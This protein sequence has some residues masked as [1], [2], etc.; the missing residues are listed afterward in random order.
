MAKN[1]IV[2]HAGHV[3]VNLHRGIYGVCMAN[4]RL[5]AGDSSLYGDASYDGREASDVWP[6]R[7][8]R[9]MALR[10]NAL[11]QWA[12][13]S[14]Y[15]CQAGLAAWLNTGY[16]DDGV[17]LSMKERQCLPSPQMVLSALQRL[18]RRDRI[19]VADGLYAP[20]REWRRPVTSAGQR[21]AMFFADL[22]R[23]ARRRRQQSGAELQAAAPPDWQN[24][25]TLAPPAQYGLNFHFQTDGYLSPL[26]A[27]LYD[28]QVEILFLGAG[29]AMRR[30]LLPGLLSH[31]AAWP[32]QA[33]APVIGDVACG[34]GSFLAE[35]SR[36]HPRLAMAGVD[37]SPSYLDLA[38]R[39][40]AG[41]RGP[42]MLVEGD[43]ISLPLRSNSCAALVCIYLFH[44]LSPKH[45]RGVAR[46]ISRVLAPGGRLFFLDSMQPGDQ[47]SLDGLLTLFPKAFFEPFYDSY[48]T[49][50]LSSLFGEFGLACEEIDCVFLSRRM[51]MR[52]P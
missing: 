17:A 47:P 41:H 19:A 42:C 50:D 34:T 14:L 20:P 38:R 32:R 37:R 23:V 29:Q 30:Q 12:H 26:S 25:K 48:L 16:P 24:R 36:N 7:L 9:R 3:C 44:E 52:K 8:L 10:R 15:R 39:R 13:G 49:E 28:H 5:M 4:I 11:G 35:L 2:S 27:A 45:R 46:E 43:A 6:G 1:S 31:V 22:P 33:G 21:A 18:E 51:T 40:T